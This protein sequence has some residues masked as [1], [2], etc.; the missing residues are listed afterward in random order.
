VATTIAW[1]SLE[2]ERGDPEFNLALCTVGQC[3]DVPSAEH[4]LYDLFIYLKDVDSPRA[5][6][7]GA[8]RSDPNVASSPGVV[9]FT[10]RYAR[11]R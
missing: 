6:R 11:R 9:D 1:R 4:L 8:F 2:I 10:P 5:M 3:R 7:I